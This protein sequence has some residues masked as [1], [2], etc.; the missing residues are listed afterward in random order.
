MS[1]TEIKGSCMCGQ[2]R[3]SLTRSPKYIT[4][5]HCGDCRKACG[6]HSVPWVTVLKEHFA[7]E[8]SNPTQFQSSPQVIRTFCAQCGTPLTYQHD[9]RPDEID[10]TIG[11]LDQPNRFPPKKDLFCREKLDWVDF[12]TDVHQN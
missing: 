11:S 2:I 5:C 9:N 10:I 3:F 7:L 8:S 1:S 4:M 12:S 6:S